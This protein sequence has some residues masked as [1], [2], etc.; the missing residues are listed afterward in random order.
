MANS[1]KR[2]YYVIVWEVPYQNDKKKVAVSFIFGARGKNYLPKI[3]TG[4]KRL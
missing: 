3:S 4:G 2:Y 1:S